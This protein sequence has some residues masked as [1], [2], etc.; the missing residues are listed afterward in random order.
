MVAGLG[1][2]W[3]MYDYPAKAK[4]LKEDERQHV[5]ANLA[6]ERSVATQASGAR[7]VHYT[8]LDWKVWMYS[9]SKFPTCCATLTR[10]TR[11]LLPVYICAITPGYCIAVFT[12]TIITQL[13]YSAANAQLLTV[14]PCESRS[15]SNILS[16]TDNDT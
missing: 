7:Y 8:F 3:V 13:G 12:P 16:C 1:S 11:L 9:C 5:L 10:L 14:P 15:L 2:Y 4:F 6:I